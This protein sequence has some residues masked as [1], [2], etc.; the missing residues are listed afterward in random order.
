MSYRM[1][2]PKDNKRILIAQFNLTR[3]DVQFLTNDIDPKIA[4]D[5]RNYRVNK[6]GKQNGRFLPEGIYTL[7]LTSI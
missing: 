2:Q 1:F 3:S 4:F 5:G 7:T 6:L